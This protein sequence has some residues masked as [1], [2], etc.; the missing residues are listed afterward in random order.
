MALAQWTH[1]PEAPTLRE[2]MTRLFEQSVIPS[3]A[4]A[5]RGV[6][7]S[8]PVDVY[9]EGDT[10]VIE[11]AL[12]GVNPEAVTVSVLGNQVAI[13]GEYP[14]PPEGRQYLCRERGTGRFERILYLPT[15]LDAD[16]TEARYENGRLRLVVPKAAQAKP[17][18]IRVTEGQGQQA[19]ALAGRTG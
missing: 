8:V 7:A 12:P 2:A 10:Y 14:A 16:Q 9:A 4:W 17:R 5:G 11:A 15:E 13:S 19:P 18:R 6:P 3:L 1:F